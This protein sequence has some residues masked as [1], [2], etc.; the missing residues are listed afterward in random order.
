MNVIV[1]DT[2]AGRRDWANYWSCVMRRLAGR[3]RFRR[4]SWD[5]GRRRAVYEASAP[6][7]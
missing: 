1:R 2:E 5:S 3:E 6:Q 4:L 7:M